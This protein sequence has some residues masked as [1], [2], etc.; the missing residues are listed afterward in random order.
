MHFIWQPCMHTT[1]THFWSKHFTK[2]WPFLKC[3]I[4]TI[5]SY[6]ILAYTMFLYRFPS[7]P[8]NK[9]S[10]FI[11]LLFKKLQ[12]EK[13]WILSLSLEGHKS[14]DRSPNLMTSSK[15]TQLSKVASLKMPSYWGLG[16]QYVNWGCGGEAQTSSP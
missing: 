4:F 2:L 3:T 8:V 9:S 1:Y 11:K 5:L 15:P 16:V 7:I 10:Q 14:H 6:S 12:E 13:L